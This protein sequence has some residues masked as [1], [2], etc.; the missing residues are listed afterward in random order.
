MQQIQSPKLLL[1]SL[2]VTAAWT[3]L[4]AEINAAAEALDNRIENAR[5]EKQ[6]DRRLHALA[7]IAN[8]LPL[9]E[10]PDALKAADNLK[11]LRERLAFR[12]FG[13]ETLG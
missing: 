8:V 12:G 3:A 2:L 6:I 7:D 1:V 11:S 4:A 9:A 5:S 10:I 13:P